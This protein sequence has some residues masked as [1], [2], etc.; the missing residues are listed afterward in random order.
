MTKRDQLQLTLRAKCASDYLLPGTLMA[1]PKGRVVYRVLEVWR[2]RRAGDQRYA[3]R[4]VCKRPGR[5]EVPKGAVVLPWP[6]EPRNSRAG[7]RK[8]QSANSA[9]PQA[10]RQSRIEERAERLAR[11]RRVGRDAGLVKYS[12]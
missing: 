4:L 7:Q 12:D 8:H 3:L 6:C 10:I 1:S 5:S 11:A 9:P 2:V